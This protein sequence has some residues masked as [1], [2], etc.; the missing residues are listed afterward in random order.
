MPVLSVTMMLTSV[1]AQTG[2][3]WAVAPSEPGSTIFPKMVWVIFELLVGLWPFPIVSMK[4]TPHLSLHVG[5]GG[6]VA[7][8]VGDGV[9]VGVGG[10]VIVGVAVGDAVGV[11][12]G[13]IVGVADGV[14]IA[15]GVGVADGVTLG[16][17]VV[18][19]PARAGI[20]RPS[21]TPNTIR[22]HKNLVGRFITM[23]SPVAIQ[24][25]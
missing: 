25:M 21:D 14:G 10:G 24:E 12:D 5:S 22:L 6:G 9:A 18:V 19:G 13:V 17:G 3:R 8:G 2:M 11:G 15:L 1:P 20:V 16:V 4:L 7:V 23:I